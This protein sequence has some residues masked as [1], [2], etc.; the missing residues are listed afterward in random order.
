MGVPLPSAMDS[1]ELLQRSVHR[2]S[3]LGWNVSTRSISVPPGNGLA[4]FLAW[5]EGGGRMVRL[6]PAT[7]LAGLGG[8]GG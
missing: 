5:G 6:L 2:E 8:G 1:T 7:L 3:P 4:I